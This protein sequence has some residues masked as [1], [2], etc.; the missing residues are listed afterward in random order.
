MY[1]QEPKKQK[2][3]QDGE[4]IEKPHNKAMTENG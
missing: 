1:N 3:A 4:S 2:N